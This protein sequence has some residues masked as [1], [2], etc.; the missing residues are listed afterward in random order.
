M[1]NSDMF[2][3]LKNMDS[4]QLIK[5][6]DKT[7]MMSIFCKK[8]RR[9]KIKALQ[10]RIVRIIKIKYPYTYFKKGFCHGDY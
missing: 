2:K 3:D 9:P 6:L 5:L 7:T 10:V 8:D 1:K 4:S